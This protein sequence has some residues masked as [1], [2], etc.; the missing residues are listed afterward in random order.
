MN[1]VHDTRENSRSLPRWV[2]NHTRL[3]HGSRVTQRVRRIGAAQDGSA[4]SGPSA[5]MGS[6]LLHA[7]V[8][9]DRLAVGLPGLRWALRDPDQPHRSRR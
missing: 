7:T 9:L 1:G 6:R 3:A 8:D 2:I 5:A 4:P